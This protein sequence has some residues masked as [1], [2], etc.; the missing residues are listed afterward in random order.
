MKTKIL[1]Q[2]TALSLIVFLFL[3]FL[4]LACFGAVFVS[5]VGLCCLGRCGDVVFVLVFNVWV[6]VV[7]W[8]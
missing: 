3:I 8:C 5:L 7:V 4:L 2:K 1:K 6:C